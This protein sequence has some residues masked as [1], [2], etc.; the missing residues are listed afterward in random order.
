M[1]AVDALSGHPVQ[2]LLKQLD[3]LAGRPADRSKV[4]VMG[5]G[6]VGLPLTMRAAELNRFRVVG[7]DVDVSKVLSLLNGTSFIEDVPDERV[8]AA[9][10]RGFI[11]TYD[12]QDLAEF[13][14]AIIT[15]PTPLRDGVPDL[16]YI[17]SA[18]RLLGVHLRPGAT[19][20]LES[21]TYPGTTEQVLIP[22][23]SEVSGLAPGAFHVGFSPERID[24][25]NVGWTFESTPKI[26]SGSEYCCLAK[27]VSFYSLLCDHIVPVATTAEA[28]LAKV[29]ENTFRY[30]NIALVNEMAQYAHSL[31]IDIWSVIDA[32]A[33]KPYGFMKFTPGPGAGGHC[34]PIDP[35]YLSWV[36]ERHLGKTFRFVEIANDINT[37]MP[38]YVVERVIRLLNARG[39]CLNGAQVLL[40][41]LA[42]KAGSSDLR[43]TPA[44]RV[45]DLMRGLGAQVS[46]IDPHVRNWK[47]SDPAVTFVETDVM[48]WVQQADIVVLLTDHTEFDY[49]AVSERAPE[50]LDCRHAFSA[51]ANVHYL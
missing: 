2:S 21:T 46:V 16:S 48:S 51:S 26:V 1:S 4:V 39:K 8:V 6:Y 27:I 20:V 23:L 22:L 7:F 10:S 3:D 41:G 31:G 42:Y 44:M 11:P 15:V 38:D 17:E 13:D 9:L 30:V 5:Q 18:A 40:M 32:A 25:G 50:V 37:H 12:E 34:L 36:V 28:E 45:I 43:E 49:T 35:S 33:T 29:L 19:V 24:P 14:Y 47:H